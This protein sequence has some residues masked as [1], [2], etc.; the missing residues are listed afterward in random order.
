MNQANYL[1]EKAL[2]KRWEISHRTLQ[3]WRSV[4]RGPTYVR[5]GS[6]V[7]YAKEVID[8]FEAANG[9]PPKSLTQEEVKQ[10]AK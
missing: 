7:R 8:A 1:S 5:L 2:A 9:F 4:E 3:Y 6:H 10:C